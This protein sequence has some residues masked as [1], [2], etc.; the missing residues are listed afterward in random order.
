[1]FLAELPALQSLSIPEMEPYGPLTLG[2]ALRSGC[3]NLEHVDI[4]YSYH[5]LLPSPKFMVISPISLLSECQPTLQSIAIKSLPVLLRSY[6]VADAF[7]R[8]SET[9]S[10]LVLTSVDYL[11]SPCL[12]EIL[13]TRCRLKIFKVERT[14]NYFEDGS[15]DFWDQD[16]KWGLWSCTGLEVLHL[17]NCGPLW[18]SK[19][20]NVKVT[21]KVKGKG[22]KK[23]VEEERVEVRRTE[24]LASRRYLWRQIGRMKALREIEMKSTQIDRRLLIPVERRVALKELSLGSVSQI[25]D[26]IDHED[27]L[28]MT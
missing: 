3:P 26:L 25:Q 7:R 4:L 16:F 14:R 20:E 13:K 1:M 18:H 5:Q 19:M 21:V 2:R 15:V 23:N 22:K 17:K 24:H 10:S 8:H 9:L 27:D 6:P 28:I 12:H 11:S